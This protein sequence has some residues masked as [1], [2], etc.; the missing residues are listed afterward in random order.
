MKNPLI[1]ALD[2]PSLDKAVETAKAIGDVAGGFKV[3]LTL[4]AAAGPDAVRAIDAPVFLDLK[5]HDI[6]HQVEGTMRALAPLRPAMLTVHALGGRPMLETSAAATPAGTALLAVTILTSLHDNAL[7]EM[8]LPPIAEAVPLLAA[9]AVECGCNGVVCS[10]ADLATVRDVVPQDFLVVTPGVRS[11][12]DDVQD[13]A[14]VATAAE[15]IAAGAT[16]IVVGRPI[17]RASNPRAAAETIL[18]EIG[19]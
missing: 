9:L 14:R 7:A 3:G 15:A 10:P 1:V 18:R 8:R 16:H 19:A 4:W 17:T 11:A 13:Q 5:L 6:P 2:V 12:G